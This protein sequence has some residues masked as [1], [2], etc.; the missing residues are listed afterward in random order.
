MFEIINS[1]DSIEI[2]SPNTLVI[3]DIDE[4]II[5]FEKNAYY[6]Y[7]K[8]NDLFSED[9]SH[10]DLADITAIMYETHKTYNLPSHTDIDGFNR[11]TRKLEETSGKLIFL[12][13]RNIKSNETTKKDLSSIFINPY[14]YSIH[15]TN[16]VISKGEYINTYI[17]LDGVNDIIFIDDLDENLYSFHC[18]FPKS[19]YYKFIYAPKKKN[20]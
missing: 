18:F 20:G 17:D 4:T 6:F 7:Y 8:L 19:K 13:A 11:L 12:T 14:Q 15:Y 5:H 16:N 3:C 2:T 10:N 9:F 1:F